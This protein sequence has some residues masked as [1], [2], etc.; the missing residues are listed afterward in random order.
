MI[1]FDAD[2]LIHFLLP[3][4]VVKHKQANHLY[5]SATEKNQFFISL[6]CLQEIAFVLHKLGQKSED[7][8]AMLYNFLSS[9]PVSYEVSDLLRAIELGKQIGFNNTNDCIHL[10]IAEAYCNEIY[11]FNKS[12][13]KRLQNL[14]KLK[15]TIL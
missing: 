8:E 6:L 5:Q 13:F 15:I 4:D 1:Y 7:I 12:D 11:T 9:R 2:V 14:T 10:A 3:Q